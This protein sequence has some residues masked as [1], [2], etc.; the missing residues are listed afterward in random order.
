MLIKYGLQ[1]SRQ[2]HINITNVNRFC[3]VPIIIPNKLHIGKHYMFRLVGVHSLHIFFSP[4]LISSHYGQISPYKNQKFSETYYLNRCSLA[5]KEA[6]QQANY[7][8]VLC[9]GYK[10]SI[11]IYIYVKQAAE[12]T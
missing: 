8:V 5:K 1:F 10:I 7:L 11:S 4:H 3:R 6:S 2:Y 9:L 12:N